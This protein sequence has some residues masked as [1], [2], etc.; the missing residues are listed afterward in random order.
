MRE[1]VEESGRH[2]RV[3]ED[4][5]PFAEGEIGRDDDRRALVEPADQVEQQLSAGLGEG[6]IAQLV[7]HDEVETRQM[8]G[9]ASLPT[10]TPLGFQFVD[11][12][13]DVEE[14]ATS[15]CANAGP[16]DRD[17][18]VILYREPSSFFTLRL[19]APGWLAAM[20]ATRSERGTARR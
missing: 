5:G 13:D 17:G 12:V 2:F 7:E 6:Q 3:T 1:P 14:P 10:G 16:S 19:S 15:T 4:A 8:I 9:D 20:R 18:S 11:E